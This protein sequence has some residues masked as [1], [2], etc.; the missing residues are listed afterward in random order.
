MIDKYPFFMITF[1]SVHHALR[2]ESRM[3]GTG[4]SFQL[5][6]VPRE[7]SS[8]CGVAAKVTNTVERTLIDA[9]EKT[10]IEFDSIYL[11]ESPKE[12]PRL[13]RGYS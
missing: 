9:V 3:K 6:P 12:K 4:I 11:Y 13:I 1:P 7:I 2:F 5:V 10:G 8:S